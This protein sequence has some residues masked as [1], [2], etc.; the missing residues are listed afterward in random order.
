M[1]PSCSTPGQNVDLGNLTLSCMFG[2]WWLTYEWYPHSWQANPDS[3]SMSCSPFSLTFTMYTSSPA[4]SGDNACQCQTADL[5]NG[6]FTVTI[7][8]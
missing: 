4:N 7:T 3:A 6:P 8:F 5:T 1:G 2:E